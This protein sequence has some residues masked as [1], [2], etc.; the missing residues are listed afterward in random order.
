MRRMRKT[1]RHP[2]T[3][4]HRRR[5]DPYAGFDRKVDLHG[6]KAVDA[7]RVLLNIISTSPGQKI[8]VN[9]GKGEGVLRVLVR[10]ICSRDPRIKEM[11]RGE[12]SV[13]PGGDGITI[14]QL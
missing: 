4:H 8:L 13:V 7:E 3:L 10:N 5:G 1:I 11:R 6:M 14:V 2:E 12:E 9:H